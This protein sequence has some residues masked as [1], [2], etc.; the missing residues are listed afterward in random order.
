[1]MKRR[2]RKIAYQWTAD[3]LTEM[4][5]LDAQ[6]TLKELNKFRIDVFPTTSKAKR[7]PDKFRTRDTGNLSDMIPWEVVGQYKIELYIIDSMNDM[8][9]N[10]GIMALTHGLGHA[11]FYGFDRNRRMKY[12]VFDDSG[13]KPGEIGNW[14]TVGI[15]NKTSAINKVV[16]HSSDPEVYNHIYYLETYRYF[17][18][19]K[20]V[21]YR[22]YDFRDD[23]R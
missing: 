13:H 18:K 6:R 4:N 7:Y 8:H 20:P 2:I 5:E 16:Q 22:V 21:K 19:W 23:I 3:H 12:T 1:M 15:H 9:L 10:S 14:H 11:L 17:N